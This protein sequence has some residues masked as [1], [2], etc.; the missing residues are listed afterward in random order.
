MGLFPAPRCK[1]T[2]RVAA[3]RATD[4]RCGRL[5]QAQCRLGA[6]DSRMPHVGYPDRNFAPQSGNRN[7]LSRYRLARS[8]D[9]YGR[10]MFTERPPLRAHP[11]LRDWALLPAARGGRASIWHR[12]TPAGVARMVYALLGS[13]DRHRGVV[14]RVGMDFRSISSTVELFLT[15]G[16]PHRDGREGNGFTAGPRSDFPENQHPEKVQQ[17]R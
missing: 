6:W 2:R 8:S 14:L 17:S 1:L 15:A 3:R 12:P 11:L 9:G 7:A 5:R 13:R 4:E 10:G 16:S